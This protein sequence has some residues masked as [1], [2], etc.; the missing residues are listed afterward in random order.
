MVGGVKM[1][2]ATPA[3]FT[4]IVNRLGGGGVNDQSSFKTT[5]NCTGEKPPINIFNNLC[6]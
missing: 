4:C 1:N 3:V 5:N 2:F 6:Y